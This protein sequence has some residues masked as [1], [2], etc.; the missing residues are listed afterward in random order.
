MGTDIGGSIRIPSLFCGLY[1][2]KSSSK[3]LTSKGLKKVEKRGKTGQT[4][5]GTVIGPISKSS[6]DLVEIFKILLSEEMWENDP[7]ILRKPWDEIEF[8][9]KRKLRIGYTTENEMF[10]PSKAN[11]RAVIEV[12]INF[13]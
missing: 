4:A 7:Y 3:R 5:I 8:S 11:K 12:R 6:R 9:S 10:N 1:G 13:I 2:I